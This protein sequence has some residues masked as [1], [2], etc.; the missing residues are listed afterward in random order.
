MKPGFRHFNIKLNLL[1][2]LLLL[3]VFSSAQEEKTVRDL[4]L[5]TEVKLEK[6]IVKGLYLSA[7]QHLRLFKDF[8]QVDDY[9]TELE[10]EY[11]INKNFTLGAAGRYTKNRHYDD[12]VENDYRY[13]FYLGYDGKLS[14][15]TK[16][17]YRFKY[18]K[19]FYGSG[20]FD[21]HLHYYETTFRNRIK[22]GWELNDNHRF[23]SSAEIFR[24]SKK[25]REPFFD[26]YRIFIGDDILT[27]FGEFDLAAG[28]DH[29]LNT[30]NPCT[31]FILKVVYKISL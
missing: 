4:N 29:E 1:F 27:G 2:C 6:K 23:Y 26:K 21:P 5:W 24:L 18:Q 14:P 12:I 3:Y 17:Y 16:L 22:I 19:E 31:C 7:G 15:K 11:K 20:V 13:D 30:K 28:L 9:I 10:L 25:S 8:T